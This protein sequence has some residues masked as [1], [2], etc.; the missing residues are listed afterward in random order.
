MRRYVEVRIYKDDGGAGRK[1]MARVGVRVRKFEAVSGTGSLAPTERRTRV[2]DYGSVEGEDVKTWEEVGY[3]RQCV[4]RF[5]EVLDRGSIIAIT[6]GMSGAK[7][8]LTFVYY[9][10]GPDKDEAGN[11]GRY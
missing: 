10:T 8:A 9:Y 7:M 11:I 3:C 6:E 5:L 1:V 4:V 2:T